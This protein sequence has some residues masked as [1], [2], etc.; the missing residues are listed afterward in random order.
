MGIHDVVNRIRGRKRADGES[1]PTR[2]RQMILSWNKCDGDHWCSFSRV[3][4]DH[5]HFERMEGVYVIWHAGQHPATVYVGQGHI[6]AR[7]RNHRTDNR[8]LLYSHYGLFVTWAQVTQ[9]YRSRVERFL[10]DRLRPL[11]NENRPLVEPLPVNI[12]W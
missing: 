9:S 10:I 6:A 5:A 11:V 4:L 1:E 7:L 12:P 3:N 8:I 2:D